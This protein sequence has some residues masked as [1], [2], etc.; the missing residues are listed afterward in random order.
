MKDISFLY[1]AE[2]AVVKLVPRDTVGITI[3]QKLN[4]TF[5]PTDS[6]P[7]K[8]YFPVRLKAKSVG[9]GGFFSRR[10][11]SEFER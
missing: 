4:R 5:T 9:G 1:R 6:P 2:T 7:D 3:S 8:M 11:G 10:Q